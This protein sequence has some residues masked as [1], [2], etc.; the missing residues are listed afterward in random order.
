VRSQWVGFRGPLA[1]EIRAFIDA[2]RAIGRR[3]VSKEK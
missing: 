3:Y 1:R 2:K